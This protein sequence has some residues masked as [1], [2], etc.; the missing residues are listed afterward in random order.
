MSNTTSST[1][2]EIAE[3]VNDTLIQ[4]RKRI[5]AHGAFPSVSQAKV[6]TLLQSDYTFELPIP[7]QTVVTDV[8][9]MMD[10]GIVHP[11][12]PRYCGL[13]EPNVSQ[14]AIIGD[15]F[16]ALYNPQL[17]V[18]SHAP[19]AHAIEQH[20]LK[21]LI[22]QLGLE[23]EK[24]AAHFTSGG[25]EANLTAVLAALN[26]RFPHW[27]DT[28]AIGCAEQPVFYAS[29]NA[30]HSFEKAA[31]IAGIGHKSLHKITTNEKF[32]ID[33]DALREQIKIDRAQGQVPFMIIATFGATGSG[34]IDPIKSLLT[35]CEEQSLWLH[36]DAAWGGTAAFAPEIKPF[37]IGIEKVDSITWDAHKWLPIPMGAGMFFCAHAEAL[38]AAFNV[39]TPYIPIS[40]ETY[41][42][43]LSTTVQWSRRFIGLKVFMCLAAL[44]S[45]GIK[46]L[47]SHQISIGRYLRQKLVALGWQ[48]INATPLPIVCFTKNG[49]NI[50][51]LLTQ[52]EQKKIGWISRLFLSDGRE[53]LRGCITNYKTEKKDIDQII[54]FLGEYEN[55]L[56]SM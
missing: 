2:H 38:E 49:L 21:W 20:T 19:A 50:S 27:R 5:E 31:A 32:E 26:H 4:M 30:H 51:S 3:L 37:M 45:T 42:N 43:P 22:S 16:T 48:V 18:Q 28:G 53:V 23:P 54:E 34:S 10:S 25:M 36:V 8:Q 55:E 11:T 17:S 46:D 44:G 9:E 7:L 15:L 39:L 6:S 12:H 40:K 41:S 35:L 52:L 47:V 29:M 24:Y 1:I 33:I 13:F 56:L 14:A